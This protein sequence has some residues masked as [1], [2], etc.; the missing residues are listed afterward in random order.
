MK[1]KIFYGICVAILLWLMASTIEVW[2][3]NV[4]EAEEPY[5]KANAW[6]IV[7]E[8]NAHKTQTEME[9]VDCQGVYSDDYEVTVEDSNGNLWAYI[10]TE[11]KE[12]GSTLTITMDG[13]E[14]VDAK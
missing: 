13:D 8:A 14:I 5:N 10:D 11:P 2:T 12:I 4:K 9:V 6:A 1:A 3:H 7:A